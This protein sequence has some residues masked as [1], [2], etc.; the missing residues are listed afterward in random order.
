MRSLIL[1]C[2]RSA[3]LNIT[4]CICNHEEKSFLPLGQWDECVCVC[5][6]WY[7]PT[8]S[9]VGIVKLSFTISGLISTLFVGWVGECLMT[10]DVHYRDCGVNKQHF[11]L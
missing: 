6:Y 9:H 10:P 7:I 11:L 8:Q 1:S 4:V 5:V 3:I 2:N